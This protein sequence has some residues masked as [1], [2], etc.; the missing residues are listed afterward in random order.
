MAAGTT[1]PTI[2]RAAWANVAIATTSGKF[3]NISGQDIVVREQAADPGVGE[4]QG[5]IYAARQGD[6]YVNTLGI[7][8]R[9]APEG[10]SLNASKITVVEW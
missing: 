7:W 3:Q 10:G 4:E 1:T 6:T 5:V 2:T 9:I 8:A